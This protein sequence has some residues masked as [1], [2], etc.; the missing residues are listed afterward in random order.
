[1]PDTL[2]THWCAGARPRDTSGDLVS[3]V[4]V[5]LKKDEMLSRCLA[6]L[7]SQTHPHLECIVI[8]NRADA[9]T[10]Q[11]WKESYPNFIFEYR[12]DNELYSKPCNDA[13]RNSAGEFI[14]CL[15][16]DCILSP[17]YIEEALKAAR[18][19]GK[20]GA[21]AGCILRED[22]KTIDSTGLFLTR[23][24]KP[25]DRG[26]GRKWESRYA[27]QGYV[28][29][30]N[31]AAAFYRRKMLEEIKTGGEYFDEDMGFYYEDLDVAWRSQKCGWKAFYCPTAVAYHKRGGTARSRVRPKGVLSE[32]LIF[33]S[34]CGELKSRLIRNRYAVIVKNDRLIDLTLCLPWILFYDVRLL[35]Y[36]LM[37]DRIVLRDVFKGRIFLTKA[38]LKR[39]MI[40]R[41]RR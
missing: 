37:F 10:A 27:R 17:P 25:L 31:A 24:R 26:Y 32:R 40:Q 39:K 6:S 1:M 23:S 12:L 8:L 34:L 38:M 35:A 21:V 16:D 5:S 9:L 36:L 28:F 18:A 2:S 4:V 29:G 20:I 41:H 15:N 7:A 33:P 13:I 30:V 19:D 3:V 14:L 22:R 11:K